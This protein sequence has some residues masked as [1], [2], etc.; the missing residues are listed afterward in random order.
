MNWPPNPVGC[1]ARPPKALPVGAEFKPPNGA[2]VEF[3]DSENIVARKGF[4][5]P[6]VPVICGLKPT[7]GDLPARP[8]LEPNPVGCG[9]RNE[10]LPSDGAGL[11]FDCPPRSGVVGADCGMGGS[12]SRSCAPND[13]EGLKALM[14]EKP[15]AC[16][17]SGLAPE[18]EDT[19]VPVGWLD[20]EENTELEKLE[21]VREDVVP[22]LS[23]GGGD[24]V[25]L[26]LLLP[27]VNDDATFEMSELFCPWL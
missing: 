6:A 21:P 26:G 2:P 11:C 1:D 18:A 19:V 5:A 9:L 7:P 20:N 16:G 13:D 3:G 10:L 24:A 17:C 25:V 14:P 4:A 27:S 22:V 23:E 15:V 12:D 8:R